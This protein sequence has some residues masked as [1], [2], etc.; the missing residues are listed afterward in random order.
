MSFLRFFHKR[1]EEHSK[2]IRMQKGNR[3]ILVIT[4][5][6]VII[7]IALIFYLFYY[8]Q[9][10][11]P[12][13][14]NNP[15]N[16]RQELYE[17]RVVRGDILSRDHEILATT[18]V[19]AEG[20][21]SRVYPYRN[22]FAHAV[23]FST[24]GKIGVESIANFKL[25]SSDVY[26]GER[27]KNDFIGKKNP[28]NKVVT[29]LD[30]YMQQVADVSMGNARGAVIAT[31]V[32]TG[33]ILALVS[34]PDFDPN[35]VLTEWDSL[36]SDNERSVFLNRATQ[37]LYPPG[38]T[39]KIV[40]ALE[41]MKEHADLTDYSFDCSG[42]FSYEGNVIN[43]YHGT[44]HGTVDFEKSFAKS[45]NSSFANISTT[46]NKRSFS[47]TCEDL[48][49]K[50]KIPS[51]YSYKQST[52]SLSSSSS[53]GEVM[54]TAIGQGKTQITPFHMNLITSAIANDGV[55]MQPYVIAGIYTAYDDPVSVTEPAEYGRLLSRNHAR[56]M[57]SLMRTVVEAGTATKLKNTFG[58]EA[59]G[60]TGSAEYSTDKKKSHAWF[61]G[62]A[63]REEP[64]IAVT[65]IVE[66][67]GS[68]GE[69][70][71]PIAKNVFDAYFGR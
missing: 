17:K 61:T 69:V 32:K 13:L 23:G 40:T 41:Y 49:F 24:H 26:I 65:V 54:Q 29:T 67:G 2:R 38:S 20:T 68:G 56:K 47:A 58:Y 27:V 1:R 44:K 52:V 50:A 5:A 16:K 12:E 45:C 30:L 31:N 60:K 3:E 70:A 19:D 36:N 46:L 11:S 4:Y 22:L 7:F 28:G 64:E 59:A 42:S 35:T 34:K 39:F 37:G 15:Y 14:I 66:D 48:L 33:E 53:V 9:F 57:Q 71:A 55:L 21:E 63:G 18:V 10:V 62:F 43:C 25:L 8:T 51:P 6:F